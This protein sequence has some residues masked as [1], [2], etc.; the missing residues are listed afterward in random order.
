MSDGHY[1]QRNEQEVILSLVG[2]RVGSFLDVGAY[3]GKTF[4]NTMALVERGWKGVLVEP[5]PVP[6]KSMLELHGHNP[7]LRLVNAAVGIE[8][9]KLVK[10]WP[11]DDAVSTIDPEH[12]Q[13]WSGTAKFF[14]PYYVPCITFLTLLV[15]F[16]DVLGGLDVLNID[17]EGLSADLMLTFPFENIKPSVVCVEHD[18]KQG[19][20]AKFME[21]YGYS[22]RLQN[23]E[24][25][26]LFRD[27]ND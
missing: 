10:F 23:E 15:A 4:S 9:G 1:S 14:E 19:K 17:V 25:L 8:F 22:S 27:R 2:E 21:R 5:S 3:D 24:N 13:K 6:F 20:L 11:T 7:S 26:I 16:S 12:Y 18:Q